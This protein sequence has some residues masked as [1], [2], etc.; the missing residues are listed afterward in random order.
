MIYYQIQRVGIEYRDAPELWWSERA[1]TP[2]EIL[3][4]RWA[5]LEDARTV[6]RRLAG[7]RIVTRRTGEP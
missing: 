5:S 6:A 1:W 3:A 2:H 7:V 4:R